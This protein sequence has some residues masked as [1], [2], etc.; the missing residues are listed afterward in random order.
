M[1]RWLRP[2]LR[3]FFGVLM[4]TTAVGKLL[5]NRGFAEVIATYQFGMLDGKDEQGQPQGA[6]SNAYAIY[7]NDAVNQIRVVAEYKDDWVTR[8][9]M[10]AIAPREAACAF[11]IRCRVKRAAGSSPTCTTSS[12]TVSGPTLRSVTDT[13]W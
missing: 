10:L 8:A 9:D 3:V 4:T 7:F 2:V 1:T 11:R 5:D 13:T 6:Y 12:V